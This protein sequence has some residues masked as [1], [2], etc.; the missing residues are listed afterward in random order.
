MGKSIIRKALAI[1]AICAIAAGSTGC[2]SSGDSSKS[3]EA[4]SEAATTT[5]AAEG[6]A[7]DTTT[8]VASEAASE[9]EP[10]KTD[11]PDEAAFKE[12]VEANTAEAVFA[13]HESI[14]SLETFYDDD[15]NTR[16]M[17]LY[18]DKDTML[19]DYGNGAYLLQ[20]KELMLEQYV[21]DDITGY[22]QYLF[23]DPSMTEAYFDN[24]FKGLIVLPEQ[25]HLI[26]TNE[27]EEGV[28]T[29][30]TENTDKDGIS[31]E[32]LRYDPAGNHPYEEGMKFCYVYR[33]DKESRDALSIEATMFDAEGEEHKI[34]FNKL[35]LDSEKY[36][37]AKEGEPFADY[38]AKLADAETSRKVTI[39]FDTGTEAE[40]EVSYTLPYMVNFAPY[41][42]ETLIEN[43]YTDPE[44]TK[45][46]ESSNGK[47]DLKLYAKSTKE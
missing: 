35:S 28:F 47:D 36:D 40:H 45:A 27:D 39:V 26:A 33:F 7:D 46:F 31:A 5:T 43:M 25:E 41:Q 6:S 13:R 18:R 21:Q 22:M 10:A 17:S 2:G 20:T 19:C 4:S 42:G 15:G 9:A 29:A 12:Y 37:P 38:F 3:S 11:E 24:T 30:K 44:C 23:D 1:A 16:E 8:T 32:L 34:V 14:S